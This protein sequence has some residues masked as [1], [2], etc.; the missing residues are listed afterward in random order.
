MLEIAEKAFLQWDFRVRERLV[1]GLR[2]PA[3]PLQFWQF[4]LRH[5]ADMGDKQKGSS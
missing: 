1:L 5:G 2:G 3:D 4:W